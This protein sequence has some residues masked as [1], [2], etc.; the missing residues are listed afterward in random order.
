[1]VGR[2]EA[3][4][5]H[6]IGIGTVEVHGE[7]LIIG[8]AI[9]VNLKVCVTLSDL[10]PGMAQRLGEGFD[11]TAAKNPVRRVFVWFRDRYL[12]T[13]ALLPPR[14]VVRPALPRHT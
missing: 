10:R 2:I 4:E 3:L 8:L 13:R 12:A 11:T 9:K 1:M 5:R 14:F 6:H 7:P